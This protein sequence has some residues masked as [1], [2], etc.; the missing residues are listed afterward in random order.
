MKIKINIE[1]LGNNTLLIYKR[2][3]YRNGLVVSDTS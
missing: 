2:S 1:E 3:I